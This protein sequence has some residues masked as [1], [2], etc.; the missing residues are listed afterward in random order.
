MID[1]MKAGT[2]DAQVTD[3]GSYAPFGSPDLS[4]RQPPYGSAVS[5][6]LKD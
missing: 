4:R 2:I 6:T 3:C 1:P 5:A